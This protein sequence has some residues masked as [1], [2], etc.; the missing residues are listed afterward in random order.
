MVQRGENNGFYGK[1]HT[2]ES[3][4]KM[5]EAKSGENNPMCGRRQS[6]ET[7]R[8]I[9]EALK[10][11][12]LVDNAG[13]NNPM[14]GRKHTDGAK[15]KISEAQMGRSTW[16]KGKKCPRLS[17]VQMGE[18]NSFYG[19]KH[20]AESRRKMCVAR[21]KRSFSVRDTS[22][23][24]ALQGELDGRSVFYEKHV[25]VCG[26]C[27]PDIVFIDEKIAVFADGNYWHSKD[28][29]DG[30]VWER[31]RRQDRVLRESGWR[32]LRFWESEINDDVSR[33]VDIVEGVI[34]CIVNN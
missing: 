33:C 25:P 23:E 3:K 21:L 32:V 31:D 10:E 11:S 22:I 34:N 30:L 16:N 29:K 18:N 8:K 12:A 28:F 26:V 4:Q 1:K 17:K 13:H 20:S 15:R 24:V 7:K 5:S 9:S 2:E 14:C 19:R 27:Q 6:E